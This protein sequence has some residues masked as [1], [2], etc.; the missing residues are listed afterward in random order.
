LNYIDGYD[1]TTSVL[2]NGVSEKV[3]TKTRGTYSYKGFKGKPEAFTKDMLLDITKETWP[4]SFGLPPRE[5]K[6]ASEE[7]DIEDFYIDA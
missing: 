4:E 1:H 7:D 6:K 3:V 2:E 5:K